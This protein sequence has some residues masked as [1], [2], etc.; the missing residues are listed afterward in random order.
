MIFKTT[1]S[2][3]PDLIGDPLMMDFRLGGY[4]CQDQG[5]GVSHPDG[6]PLLRE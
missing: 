3:I 4:D 5:V 2:V 1:S 6:F